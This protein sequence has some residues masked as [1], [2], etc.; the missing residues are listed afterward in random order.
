[1]A[2]DLD[3]QPGRI[4]ARAGALGQR[5]LRCLHAGLH[6][7]GV[8]E[9]ALHLG[10]ERDQKVD[11]TD[12]FARDTVHV[13]L[14]QGRRRQLVQIGGQ[15]VTF[16]ILIGER[17]FL[18]MRFEEEIE[19]I[20]HRHFGDQINLDTQFPGFF[21]EDQTGQIVALRILLPVDEMLLGANFQG[22]REDARPG[23]RTRTQ[24]DYLRPQIDQAI[25]GIMRNVI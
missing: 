15:F 3:E 13:F 12:F 9:I 19:G 20:D 17:D 23:V 11:A 4:A 16:P 14:E 2:Q 10:I 25:I 22:V 24:A 1:M 6:P 7:D 5:L 8:A 18:G 21:R